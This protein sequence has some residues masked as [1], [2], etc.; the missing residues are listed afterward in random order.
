MHARIQSE[1]GTL[2]CDISRERHLYGWAIPTT[3]R[4]S[5]RDQGRRWSVPS[6]AVALS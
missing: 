3:G 4:S 5:G 6:L 1:S 2:N